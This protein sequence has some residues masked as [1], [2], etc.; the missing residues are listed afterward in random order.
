MFGDAAEEAGR[1]DVT[2]GG[3][4]D[5]GMLAIDLIRADLGTKTAA[6]YLRACSSSSHAADSLPKTTSRSIS[7]DGHSGLH[8][9]LEH[10]YQARMRTGRNQDDHGGL[11]GTR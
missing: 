7:S 2:A 5:A 3:R 1:L 9:E 8:L 11:P 6:E 4:H 10:R